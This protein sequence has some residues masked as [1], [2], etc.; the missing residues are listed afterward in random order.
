MLKRILAFLIAALLTAVGAVSWAQPY[1]NAV[2]ALNPAGYWPLNETAQPSMPINLTAT[3]NGSL[4]ATGNG[5]YGAWYQPSGATWYL[6]DNIVIGSGRI[7]GG[8]GDP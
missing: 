6:D 7:T 4:G 2:M 5:Y 8:G 1:S 3:N